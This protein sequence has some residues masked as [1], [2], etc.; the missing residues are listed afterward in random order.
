MYAHMNQTVVRLL[1]TIKNLVKKS[2]INPLIYIY[3][4][5]ASVFIVGEKYYD[6]LIGIAAHYIIFVVNRK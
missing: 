1:G 3:L 6:K 4:M 2:E 5:I